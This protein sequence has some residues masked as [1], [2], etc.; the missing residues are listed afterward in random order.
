MARKDDHI[1]YQFRIALLGIEPE[2]WRRIQVPGG[3]TFWDLHVAIQNSMGW[4]D[5]HLHV[6]RII[7]KGNRKPVV[8]GIPYEEG[9]SDCLPGWEVSLS[10]WLDE[11]GA[12][13][14]YEY[15][16]GD[17]WEHKILLEAVML[18]EEGAA[19][20]RCVGGERA[21]PPED[22]GGIPGYAFL[23]EI[24]GDPDHKEYEHRVEWLKEVAKDNYPFDPERFEPG[25][26]RFENPKKRWFAV[27]GGRR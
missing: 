15:D 17:G 23:L 11:P 9:A 18:K 24:L 21:C 7:R 25:E 26:V 6:F 2:I 20:P 19:F 13:M 16:F 1:V 5:R 3:Y 4:Q 8:I 22:C 12:A 27:F 14:I 10:E